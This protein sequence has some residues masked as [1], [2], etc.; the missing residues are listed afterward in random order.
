MVGVRRTTA[1][2]KHA[3]STAHPNVVVVARGRQGCPPWQVA[4]PILARGTRRRIGR[5]ACAMI[6]I[7]GLFLALVALPALA[8][9]EQTSW[10]EYLFPHVVRA[11][12]AAFG[13]AEQLPAQRQTASDSSTTFDHFTYTLSWP[14]TLCDEKRCLSEPEM[15]T[16]HG[17]WPD[18]KSAGDYPAFCNRNYPFNED[19]I[20]DLLPAMNKVWPDLLKHGDSFWKHEWEKHGTCSYPL[21]KDEHAYF[22]K[23]IQI[24]D[25]LDPTVSENDARHSRFRNSVHAQRAHRCAT[26]ER[27]VQPPTSVTLAGPTDPTLTRMS[28]RVRCES[29]D[30]TH[31][32]RVLQ[33]LLTH[34]GFPPSNKSSYEL[35]NIEDTLYKAFGVTP[36]I[37]CLEGDK[38]YQVSGRACAAPS[39]C[40]DRPAQA[41]PWAG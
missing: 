17:L 3:S 28:C 5:F 34:A 14:A 13:G 10:A 12:R 9:Q 16:I 26:Q 27:K 32:C 21:L 19:E 1:H 4:E 22:S 23:A 15:F 35:S 6:A 39:M 29:C 37:T 8:Q 24:Y 33:N 36:Q 41:I 38:I 25:A 2:P 20:K 11:G 31:G 40:S 7:H 30:A 18:G